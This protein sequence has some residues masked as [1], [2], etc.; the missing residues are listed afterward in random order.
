M[1]RDNFNKIHT[2]RQLKTKTKT[3]PEQFKTPIEMVSRKI[4]H[5]LSI[6]GMWKSSP[7]NN[8]VQWLHGEALELLR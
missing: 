5:A 2:Q 6:K 3:L 4:L 8:G 1:I 7:Y